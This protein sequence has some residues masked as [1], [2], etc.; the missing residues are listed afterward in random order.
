LTAR[1]HNKKTEALFQG[2]KTRQKNK[3]K[4]QGKKTRQKTLF[5]WKVSA[6]SI[7]WIRRFRAYSPT[8]AAATSSHR[9]AVR[10]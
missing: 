3:A 8:R 4:K 7:A 1:I 10:M 6:P 5:F 2:K 9:L